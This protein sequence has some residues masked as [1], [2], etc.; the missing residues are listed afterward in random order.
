MSSPL[1][2][3]WTLTPCSQPKVAQPESMSM[4]R[5]LPPTKPTPPS[6]VSPSWAPPLWT[7]LLGHLPPE[8]LPLGRLPLGRLPLGHIP[9]RRLPLSAITDHFFVSHAIGVVVHFVAIS[10]RDADLAVFSD[11]ASDGSFYAA[12]LPFDLLRIEEFYDTRLG[13]PLGFP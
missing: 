1:D 10:T 9:L 3:L 4:P 8:R 5:V 7:P 12:D 2:T 6:W 13:V 11:H